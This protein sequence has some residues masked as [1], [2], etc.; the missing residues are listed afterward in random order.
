VLLVLPG[1]AAAATLYVP[2]GAGNGIQVVD[3]Q[4]GRVVAHVPGIINPH[5]L[6]ITPDGRYL[7]APSAEK[8]SAKERAMEDRG[9]KGHHRAHA[10]RTTASPTA[11]GPTAGASQVDIIRAS[12]LKVVRRIPFQTA[13]HHITVS[14]DGRYAVVTHRDRGE[15]SIIDMASATTPAATVKVDDIDVG[16]A[17]AY[18]LVSVDSKSVFVSDMMHNVVSVV[19][20]ANGDIRARIPV[21]GGPWH[22]ALSPDGRFLYTANV[23]GGTVSE[24]SVNLDK[25]VRS[26]A[27]GGRVHG[28]AVSE[29]GHRLFVA[30]MTLGRVVALDLPSGTR[31]DIPIPVPYHVT[32]VAGSG[33]VAV[34]SMSRAELWLLSEHGLRVVRQIPINGTGHQIA[35]AHPGA[36]PSG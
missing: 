1:V 13:S 20:A 10:G 23:A 16:G 35:V 12:D 3:T 21:A 18:A 36:G 33:A 15:I 34:T 5:G 9:P 27:I 32:T 17:P 11:T 7:I 8:R 14:P 28:I 22:M 2:M 19:D 4:A 29:N 24:I 30:D 6:A 31:H 25:V 26:Y